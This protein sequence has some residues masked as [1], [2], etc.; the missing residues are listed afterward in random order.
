MSCE[1]SQKVYEQKKEYA[2]HE[3]NELEISI[4]MLVIC[5]EH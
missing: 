5:M 4:K 2:A 1:I 3:V